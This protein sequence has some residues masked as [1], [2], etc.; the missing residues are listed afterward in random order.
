MFMA[1]RHI[2][3][4]TAPLWGFLYGLVSY[5]LFNYWLGIFYPPAIASWATPSTL[6][7]WWAGWQP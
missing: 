3:L 1:V 2:R 4:K 7:P 6:S 5:V